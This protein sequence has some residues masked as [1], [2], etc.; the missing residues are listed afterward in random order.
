MSKQKRRKPWIRYERTYC[1]FLVHTDY[2]YTV[3][4]WY[5]CTI[6]DDVSRKILAAGE[7]DY[8][9]SENALF[10][11]RQAIC[12]CE[13]WNHQILAVFTDHGSEFYDNKRDANGHVDHEIVCVVCW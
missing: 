7:F 4:G 12:E 13:F 1:L 11:L 10:V 2:Y 9:T 3:D 5:L 6:L 8:K